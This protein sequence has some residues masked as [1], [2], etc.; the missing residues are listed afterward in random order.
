LRVSGGN[1]CSLRDNRRALVIENNRNEM[2]QIRH[3]DYP[4][5]RERNGFRGPRPLR[6]V[7]LSEVIGR[8]GEALFV[9]QRDNGV[10]AHG[11]AR[12]D[13]AGGERNASEYCGYRV[14]VC[15]VVWRDAVEKT[16]H[17]AAHT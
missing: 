17:G 4:S 7:N 13:V 6:R 5:R 8:S 11:T 16:S 3:E 10:D 12:G 14:E 9:S 2:T 1:V 15:E